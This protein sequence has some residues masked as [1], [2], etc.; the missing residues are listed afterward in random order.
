MSGTAK[1]P[2]ENKTVIDL[3]VKVKTRT[4]DICDDVK[5]EYGA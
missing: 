1:Q 5:V 3:H 2:D 4:A